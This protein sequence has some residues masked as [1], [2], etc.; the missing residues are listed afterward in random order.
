[1]SLRRCPTCDKQ[2]RKGQL[3]YAMVHGALKGC[4]VCQS[5]ATG[6]VVVV[7]AQQIGRCACG[8]SAKKLTTHLQA[9]V[10]LAEKTIA[11]DPGTE[12]IDPD[13]VEEHLRG[14]IEGLEAAIAAIESGKFT[15]E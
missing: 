7:A 5:C 15:E 10:K 12:F 8:K 13:A 4:I 2:F 9:F 1:M 11:E 14:R 6:G 3:V